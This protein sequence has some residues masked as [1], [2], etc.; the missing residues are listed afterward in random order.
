[1]MGIIS[2]GV[3][4]MGDLKLKLEDLKPDTHWVTLVKGITKERDEDKKREV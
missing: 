3:G 2:R 4:V 1:M